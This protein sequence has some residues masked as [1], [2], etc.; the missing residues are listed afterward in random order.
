LALPGSPDY[1][2]TVDEK[3]SQSLHNTAVTGHA[4]VDF[5][6]T[7]DTLIY[8]SY[9]H[10]F[11]AGA[12][13][14]QFLFSPADFSTVKPETIDS[15]ELGFKTTWLED[16]LQLDGALFHYQ[17]KNQQIVDVEP[18]G[19]Q[20]LINLP[21]S[22][23]EG[24]ELELVTRPV[25]S[26]T[27]RGGLGLLDAKVQEGAVAG[28]TVSVVGHKLPEAPDLSATMAADWDAWTIDAGRLVLHLD[29][30]YASKQYFELVN[31]NR[32][33]QDRYAL[34]NARVSWHAADE[35]WE[36][37]LWDNNLTNRFY[38]TNSY[39][40]QSLGFDYLHR[41][42]PRMYGIDATYHF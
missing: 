31:E 4:G 19:D 22:K 8:L 21:R 13:N 17:Y 23:I 25:R 11:R 34:L 14:A 3:R 36:L 38:L 6:P 20:P 24:A 5:T 1:A 9:S 32:I 10:G 39:D 41:G 42:L 27:F 40:L 18:T 29:S 33:A 16:R 37:G 26:L 2:A 28:G 7:K 35:K 15:I 12:F 30:S